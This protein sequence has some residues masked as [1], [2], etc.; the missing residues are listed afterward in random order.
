[1]KNKSLF[2]PLKAEHYESFEQSRKDKEYRLCGK[3]WN[4]K[5]CYIRRIDNKAYLWRRS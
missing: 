3:R 5:T 1:M 2:I 4:N